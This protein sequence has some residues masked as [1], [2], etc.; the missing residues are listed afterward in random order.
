LTRFARCSVFKE[1]GILPPE[2]YDTTICASNQ[3]VSFATRSD[4]LRRCEGRNAACFSVGTAMRPSAIA[5]VAFSAATFIIYHRCHEQCKMF[6]P[7]FLMFFSYVL[8]NGFHRMM[9]EGRWRLQP[10]RIGRCTPTVGVSL[11]GVPQ[12]RVYHNGDCTSIGC[13]FNGNVPQW[14]YTTFNERESD[15]SFCRYATY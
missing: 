7:G 12:W 5:A 14:G 4:F 8:P 15:A 13:T 3:A 9:R 10:R 11:S 1:H 2:S 6:F